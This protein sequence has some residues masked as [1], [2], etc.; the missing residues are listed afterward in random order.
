MTTDFG[1]Q[2]GG[3]TPVPIPNT[4]VKPS[5]ADGTWDECPWESRTP[6][7]FS[8]GE[9]E[10]PPRPPFSRVR[11]A[12]RFGT[13]AR[14]P[15]V[16]GV[17][18]CPQIVRRRGPVAVV[19]PAAG[20]PPGRAGV[21][22]V[23]GAAARGVRRA[24]PLVIV[25]LAADPGAGR[26]AADP[27]RRAR[28]GPAPPARGAPPADPGVV[29]RAVAR[30]EPRALGA[31]K[32]PGAGRAVVRVGARVPGALRP[33]AR[34]AVRAPGAGRAVVRGGARVPGALRPA[35]REA[36]RAAAAAEVM[37]PDVTLAD[38]V[39]RIVRQGPA[40]RPA[41]VAG[42][43]G[44]GAPRAPAPTEG[45]R[46]VARPTRTGRDGQPAV[47]RTR[48]V[49]RPERRGSPS[50]GSTR[51]RVPLHRGPVG[52]RGGHAAR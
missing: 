33:A 51:G 50:G 45:L 49:H 30:G 18:R 5:S 44:T 24:K 12:A 22:R 27:A 35:A 26:R 2:S 38:R 4:E 17:S 32:A 1:G 48:T 8:A 23:Q 11:A 36:R 10:T 31:V 25:P 39:P 14:P 42:P 3:V 40:G 6:P 37:T 52:H 46:R 41:V 34:E 9:V 29:R 20:A 28:G 15:R 19:D 21:V 43:E 13:L 16:T 7:D 47:R